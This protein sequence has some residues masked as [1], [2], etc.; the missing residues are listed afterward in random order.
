LPLISLISI[1]GFSAYGVFTL[2]NEEEIS[3]GNVAKIILTIQ[4]Y[5]SDR[6]SDEIVG[7]VKNVG[8]GTAEWVKIFFTLFK[9]KEK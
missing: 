4:K 1:N 3:S 7:Q 6:F 9:K 5:K 8:N 2:N